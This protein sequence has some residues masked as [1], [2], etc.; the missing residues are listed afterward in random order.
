[1][2][3]SEEKCPEPQ[4]L[5]FRAWL[6][7]KHR[8]ENVLQGKSIAWPLQV[9]AQFPP[10][11]SGT[12]EARSTECCK[13]CMFLHLI[14]PVCDPEINRIGGFGSLLDMQTLG[15]TADLLTGTLY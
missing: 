5:V 6:Y 12:S 3:T 9:G 7:N 11:L 8:R 13:S 2:T 4:T 15:P 10:E 14:A 1:M